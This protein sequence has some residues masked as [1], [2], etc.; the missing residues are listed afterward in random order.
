M[1]AR[2]TIGALAAAAL[3]A[4]AVQAAPAVT[5]ADFTGRAASAEAQ[6]VADWALGARDAAGR[7]FLVVDKRRA[8]LFA[9]GADGRLRGEAPVLLGQA[10]GDDT[11][12]GVGDKPLAQVKPEERTTPA[13]RFQ[14]ELGRNAGGE[15][16]LWVDYDA[17]VSMHRVRATN[18]AERRLQRLASPSVADNR[19]SW[20][21][22]NVPAAFFNSI[23]LPLARASAPV[24]YVL[25]EQRPLREVF[26]RLPPTAPGATA[27]AG[28][29][30]GKPSATRR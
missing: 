6:A 3:L 1:D 27:V 10:R 11:V 9:F 25:P 8:R 13:G 14:G 20:G 19:I 5:K 23:V 2:V 24:V 30:G 12:P 28:L 29:D 16:V 21:C 17:A 7:P 4:G 18:P 15:E 22:I 26:M